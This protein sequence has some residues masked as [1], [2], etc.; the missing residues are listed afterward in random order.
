MIAGWDEGIS[1]MKVG[2]KRQIY[3]PADLGYGSTG[4]GE[5]IP[6]DAPLFFECE[7]KEVSSGFMGAVKTVPGGWFGIILAASFIPYAIPEGV[8]PDFWN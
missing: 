3:V 7:L 1:T 6:P 8:R 2:G 4:A 5:D